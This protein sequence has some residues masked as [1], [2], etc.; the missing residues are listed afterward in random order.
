M[1]LTITTPPRNSP[2]SETVKRYKSE[3]AK[4]E[5]VKISKGRELSNYMIIV[6]SCT[7]SNEYARANKK[8]LDT[9]ALIIF[10]GLHQPTKQISNETMRTISKLLRF[11]YF[12]LHKLDVST[13][14]KGT[15]N[16]EDLKGV[17]GGNIEDF[18][19]TQYHNNPKGK[20]V[21]R[22]VIYDK[23]A[24]MTKHHGQKVEQVQ[25]WERI[26]VTIKAP[27]NT[28]FTDYIKGVELYSDLQNIEANLRALGVDIRG[29]YLNYQLNAILDN[30]FLN[31]KEK[32]FNT[33]TSLERFS[34]SE[35]KKRIF[36]I[37]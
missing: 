10:A 13:D 35:S 32:I 36:F 14:H 15:T 33:V 21:Q 31:H 22:V 17:Y 29:D 24:K 2:I 18:K 11:K 25:Q 9:Y 37:L 20:N 5:I 6:S 8:S 1:G 19:G 30:R 3:G 7:A 34:K 27:K 4:V 16:K 26:E 12:K 23:L 28:T